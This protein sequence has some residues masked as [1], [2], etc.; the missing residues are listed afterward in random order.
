M[1]TI[2]YD[3]DTNP[4]LLNG[5]K[6]AILGYG[7]QGHAHALNLKES[8]C[9]VRVGLYQGSSSWA[10]AEQA[11]L[12]VMLSGEAVA[13]ADIVMI[14]TPDTLQPAIYANDVAP[15]LKAGA[16]LM[17]AHG[18]SIHY[19]QIVPP[20][21]VDVTMIAPKAPGHRVRELYIDGQGTPGLVAVY[22]DVTGNAKALAL[23][24]GSAMG[25]G[26]A[27]IIE[28]TFAEETETDLFG[29]Q[30]EIGRAHV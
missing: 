2:Y 11:G 17:F 22:Q 13:E 16:M 19:S 15:N 5:K 21:N 9:D 7:S 20:K 25:C 28:T 4:A 12:K 23:A 18:F 29:E 3:R 10:R 6:I 1:A 30:A 24:Y 14:L 8:G 27:G 26:R